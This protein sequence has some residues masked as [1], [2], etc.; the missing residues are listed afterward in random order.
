VVF[1]DHG[2]IKVGTF[3]L[4]ANRGNRGSDSSSR[5]RSAFWTEVRLAD[6]V[7]TATPLAATKP[8]EK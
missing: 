4:R 5:E 3:T 6:L 8:G 7:E 1:F 2:R